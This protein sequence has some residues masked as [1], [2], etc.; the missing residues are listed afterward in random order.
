MINKP[1]AQVDPTVLKV[2]RLGE[3]R[4]RKACENQSTG[5]IQKV[6]LLLDRP[7]LFMLLS[8]RYSKSNYHLLTPDPCGNRF[9]NIGCKI[10]RRATQHLL[11]ILG[12]FLIVGIAEDF[13]E[14]IAK[15]PHI[16]I[17]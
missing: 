4:F 12:D 7:E 1:K 13:L 2:M 5:L 8:Y 17:W 9:F 11:Y 6:N 10:S 15:Q 14:Q 16:S 3:C